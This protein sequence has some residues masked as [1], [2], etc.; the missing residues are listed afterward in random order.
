MNIKKMNQS[1]GKTPYPFTIVPFQK[2]YDHFLRVNLEIE[3]TGFQLL[4]GFQT[5]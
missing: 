4:K 3:H 1:L 2:Q 5:S